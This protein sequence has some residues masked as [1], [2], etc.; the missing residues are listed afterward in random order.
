MVTHEH[1][2][3]VIYGDT[4]MMGIVYYAN[5]L[6]FFEAGRTELLRFLAFSYRDFEASGYAMPVV[7]AQ[8]RYRASATYDDLLTL[9]TSVTEVR[10]SSVRIEYRLIRETDDRLI[11]TGMTRHACLSSNGQVVRWPEVFTEKF[12]GS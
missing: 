9:H 6:R 10:A 5:Y 7:E 3:R 2:I 11:C 8:V 1:R 12:N 4:D